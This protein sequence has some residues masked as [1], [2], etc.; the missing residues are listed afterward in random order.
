MATIKSYTSL[1]QSKKLAEILPV[2]SADMRYAPFGDTHPWFWHGHLLEKGAI[3]C[4]SL[5][6]LLGILSFPALRYDIED[7][8]GGWIVS[9]EK[10]DKGYLSYYRDNPVDTCYDMIIKLHEQKV[11]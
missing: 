6:A 8:E 1:E 5:A 4:W 11:L 2:E 7:G 9:C 10:D 3:P